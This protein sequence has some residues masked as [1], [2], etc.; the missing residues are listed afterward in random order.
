LGEEVE[1]ALLGVTL[2]IGT[3]RFGPAARRTV[4]TGRGA[5]PSLVFGVG[6]AVLVGVRLG[7]FGEASEG[8]VR[9]RGLVLAGTTLVAGAHVAGW[10]RE[11]R[12]AARIARQTAVLLAAAAPTPGART[13][14]VPVRTA[15]RL[16]DH[17]PACLP[18]SVPAPATPDLRRAPALVPAASAS[19]PR[20]V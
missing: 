10:R 18:T 9:E 15:S 16:A 3:S 2:L 12:C 14:R 7:A 11:R 8:G 13:P 5:L 6:V 20:S 17:T 4:R 19:G 1:R